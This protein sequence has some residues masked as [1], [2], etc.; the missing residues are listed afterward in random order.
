MSYGGATARATG[1]GP[2]AI[3]TVAQPIATS[4]GATTSQIENFLLSRP[5]VPADLAEEIR[6]LGN[7]QT[8]LPIPTPP[9]ASSES[10]KIDG[11]PARGID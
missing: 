7:L 6:L 5:G 3:L 1:V 2:L 10:V 8:T 4:T 11:S 9:G